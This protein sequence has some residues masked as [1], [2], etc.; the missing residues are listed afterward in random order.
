MVVSIRRKKPTRRFSSELQ[1]K[2]WKLG[3]EGSLYGFNYELCLHVFWGRAT[4]NLD[5]FVLL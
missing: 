3:I 4:Q 5:L 1:I 2:P